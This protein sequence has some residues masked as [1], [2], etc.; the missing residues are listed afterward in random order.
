M[1]AVHEEPNAQHKPHG[2]RHTSDDKERD[3]LLPCCHEAGRGCYDCFAANG[4]VGSES[5]ALQEG[6][7]AGLDVRGDPP[8]SLFLVG[9]WVNRITTSQFRNT[10]SKLRVINTS[11]PV[12][13]WPKGALD[14][15]ESLRSVAFFSVVPYMSA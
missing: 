6:G 2:T 4:Q 12:K 9:T 8:C 13:P 1:S 11:G 7:I 15:I 14:F 10:G 5:D 3:E